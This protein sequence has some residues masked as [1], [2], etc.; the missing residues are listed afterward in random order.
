M[1]CRFASRPQWPPR[2]PWRFG[3]QTVCSLSV[4]WRLTRGPLQVVALSRHR[5][6]S[7]VRGCREGGQKFSRPSMATYS[8]AFF[9]LRFVDGAPPNLTARIA[10]T[11]TNNSRRAVSNLALI[12]SSMPTGASVVLR[13]V[14]LA[15]ATPDRWPGAPPQGSTQQAPSQPARREQHNQLTRH[16]LSLPRTPLVTAVSRSTSR[17]S[18]PCLSGS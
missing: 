8:R 10:S 17:W 4:L 15:Q 3:C 18:T 7:A 9:L 13:A 11:R 2:H 1:A 6:L 14:P 12:R 5:V 16:E